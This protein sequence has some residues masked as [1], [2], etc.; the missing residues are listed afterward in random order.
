MPKNPTRLLYS[1]RGRI[2]RQTFFWCSLATAALFLVLFVFLETMVSRPATWILYPPFFWVVLA[3]AVKRLHDAG[4]SARWL[5][6]LA[7]P[8]AG[9]LWLL[10]L[11]YFR[12]GSPGENHYG[13]DPLEY[14]DYLTVD[15]HQTGGVK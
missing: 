1:W 4:Q 11:L 5:F 10:Y 15:I 13:E 7:I 2:A 9:P 12:K 8:V 14:G 6:V 3:L